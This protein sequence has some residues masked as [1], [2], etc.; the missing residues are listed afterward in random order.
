VFNISVGDSWCKFFTKIGG[1]TGEAEETGFPFY[2]V[3][4]QVKTG[5]GGPRCDTARRIYEEG[6]ES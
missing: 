5:A 3:P 2:K 6:A 1:R 4:F